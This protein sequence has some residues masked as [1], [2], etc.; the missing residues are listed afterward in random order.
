MSS[1]LKPIKPSG[2]SDLEKSG[3]LMTRLLHELNNHLSILAGHLQILELDKR[4]AGGLAGSWREIKTASDTIGEIVG[5]YVGFRHRV[6]NEAG[7]CAAS[8]LVAAVRQAVEE[9]GGARDR[10]PWRVSVP[11]EPKGRLQLEPRWI[12]HAVR[13]IIGL[14]Q[15]KNGLLTIFAPGAVTDSRGL[16]P[17]SSL[18]P[19]VQYLRFQLTWASERPVWSE[20]DLFQPPVM[21]LA[22]AIGIVRWAD[23]VVNYIHLPPAESRFWISLPMFK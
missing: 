15:A 21:P 12:S 23:G 8:E 9:A 1:S 6:H 13:E 7:F 19:Q 3:V 18:G 16:K 14:S 20:T 11:A 10:Q 22:V 17:A 4:E 2:L 5:R